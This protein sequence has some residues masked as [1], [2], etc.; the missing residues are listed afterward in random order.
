M[1]IKLLGTILVPLVC[2]KSVYELFA[3][4]SFRVLSTAIALSRRHDCAPRMVSLPR[5]HFVPARCLLPSACCCAKVFGKLLRQIEP[6]AKFRL[7]N[8]K[9]FTIASSTFLIVVPMMKVSTASNAISEMAIGNLL[10]TILSAILLHLFYLA[11]EH[12][13]AL[14]WPQ[15]QGS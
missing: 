8:K 11:C 6:L 10:L 5:P 13:T 14:S 7:R 12:L 2:T 4:R 15:T 9:W 3:L 1:L